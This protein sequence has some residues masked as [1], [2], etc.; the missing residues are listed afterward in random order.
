MAG[1]PRLP[2]VGAPPVRVRPRVVGAGGGPA[3]GSLLALGVAAVAALLV[4]RPHLPE[5][6][7]AEAD[8]R[9]R[10]PEAAAGA[11]VGPR[12]VLAA[13]VVVAG[14]RPRPPKAGRPRRR[15]LCP[16]TPPCCHTRAGAGTA[17]WNR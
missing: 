13:V 1:L 2:E 11:G 10:A 8:L 14:V 15:V 3:L 12:R 16:S 5:A 9:L 4:E 7:A 6:G 17:S